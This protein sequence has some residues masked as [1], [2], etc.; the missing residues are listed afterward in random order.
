MPLATLANQ[1]THYDLHRSNILLYEPVK[2]AYITYNY[3][4]NSGI[5][6]KL[7]SKYI[8]KIID[9]GRSYYNNGTQ[10]SLDT[11]KKICKIKECEPEC[12]RRVGLYYL[13]PRKPPSKNDYS[14]CQKKNISSDLRLI[15]LISE[16]IL[17]IGNISPGFNSILEKIVFNGKYGTKEIVKSG[18]PNKIN[19]V[20][21][22]YKILEEYITL[23]N[24]IRAN[25]LQYQGLP[26]IGDFHIYQDGRPMNF[27][28]N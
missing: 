27:V 23:P 20:I 21:D 24:K 25:E 9:Y 28:K 13:G 10:N 4:L 3:H 16:S 8:A 17:P 1:F 18:L 5:T 7:H 12:G 19:N 2:G 15:Y 22:L 26:K 6:V 11:Y 14:T